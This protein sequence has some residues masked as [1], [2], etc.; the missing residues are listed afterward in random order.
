MNTNLFVGSSSWGAS[1]I[2][3]FSSGQPYTPAF[4]AGTRTGENILSGEAENSR[5]KPNIFTVD[6]RA[7]KTFKYGIFNLQVFARIFNLFDA[8]NP[9]NVYGDTGLA[10][11]T[12][13]ERNPHDATWFTNPSFYSPPRSIQIG[14]R[15]GYK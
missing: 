12:F 14:L 3:R 5:N 1:L 8:K 7:Y 2:T 9:T 13:Q 6:L 11:F 4:E 10:D 15:L